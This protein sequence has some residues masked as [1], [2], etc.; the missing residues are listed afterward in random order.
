MFFHFIIKSK[1]VH[2]MG[3]VYPKSTKLPKG[4]YTLQL[5]L[6]YVIFLSIFMK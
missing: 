4:D 2:G 3:D 6:R 5:Y 1:R